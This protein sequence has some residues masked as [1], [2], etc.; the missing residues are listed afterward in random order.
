MLIYRAGVQIPHVNLLSSLGHEAG[1]NHSHPGQRNA[2]LLSYGMISHTSKFGAKLILVSLGFDGCLHEILAALLYGATLVLK[3]ENSPMSHLRHVDA[4][5]ITPS[6][7]ATL[8]PKLHPKL[9]IVSSE[10]IISYPM[11]NN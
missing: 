9:K 8:D 10:Q 3:D 1:R 7:L 4:A 6:M 11:R 5:D 2:Q